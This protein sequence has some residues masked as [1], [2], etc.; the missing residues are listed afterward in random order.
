MDGHETDVGDLRADPRN[1]AVMD[2][3]VVL[4]L[5]EPKSQAPANATTFKQVGAVKMPDGLVAVGAD[6]TPFTGQ[7]VTV[8]ILDTG[9]DETHPAFQGKSIG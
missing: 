5:I 3:E 9:I 2:A 4:G 8:A 7:G 6:T 1:V